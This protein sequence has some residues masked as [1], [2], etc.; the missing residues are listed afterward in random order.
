MN[1]IKQLISDC[2]FLLKK[3]LIDDLECISFINN[4][5]ST[6]PYPI[7]EHSLFHIDSYLSFDYEIF[8]GTSEFC[9]GIFAFK[10][11]KV[12]LFTPKVMSVD[13]LFFLKNLSFNLQNMEIQIQNVSN[14]WIEKIQPKIEMIGRVVKRSE[15]EVVYDVNRL[16]LLE[17]ASYSNLRN[18]R[19]KLL[20]NNK[21]FFKDV[22]LN[23]KNDVVRLIKKWNNV[24]GFKYSKN[25]EIKEI[26][27][28]EKFVSYSRKYPNK[29][30]MKI[31]YVEG[32]PLSYFILHKIDN[33]DDWG[34]LYSCKGINRLS[35]G[36]VRGVSDATYYKAF[37]IAH[38]MGIKYLNDGELGTEIGTKQH[39]MKFEPLLF[40]KSF[41]V[42]IDN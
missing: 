17:G 9:S 11:N 39:K 42:V 31:G 16:V 24:Q 33:K 36:G 26:F 4:L 20:K 6:E 5:Y 14:S 37:E 21:L 25:K 10:K 3:F 23:N 15:Q 40:L 18:A 32:V 7:F 29:V 38:N 28:A 1:N 22:D 13:G 19:N 12:V 35:D 41:D 34:I 2:G 8:T 27:V 30:I